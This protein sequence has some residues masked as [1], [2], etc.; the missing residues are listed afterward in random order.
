MRKKRRS[1]NGVLLSLSLY[2]P[3]CLFLSLCFPPHPFLSLLPLPRSC[4]VWTRQESSHLPIRKRTL[5]SNQ[6][7]QHPASRTVKNARYVWRL[8]R[9]V[10]SFWQPK[11]TKTPG[12]L[13]VAEATSPCFNQGLLRR[14]GGGFLTRPLSDTPSRAIPIYL[15]FLTLMSSLGSLELFQVYSIV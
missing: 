5:T 12:W 9:Q 8:S 14:P 7:D 3:P 6:I 4:H 13:N 11:L 15:V 10:Y 2:H 1:D